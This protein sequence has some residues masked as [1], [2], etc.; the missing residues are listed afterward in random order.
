MLLVAVGTSHEASGSASMQE[1]FCK[2]NG[3]L[4]HGSGQCMFNDG[5]YGTLAE[6]V[7]RAARHLRYG[8]Q[9]GWLAAAGK[10]DT[11]YG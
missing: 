2:T 11:V 9:F 4:A 8:A 3:S 6:V 1:P 7:R 10:A 5:P